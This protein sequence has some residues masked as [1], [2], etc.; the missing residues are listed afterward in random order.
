M[1][2]WGI[3]IFFMCSIIIISFRKLYT[4]VLWYLLTR[5]ELLCMGRVKPLPFCHIRNIFAVNIFWGQGKIYSPIAFYK[6]FLRDIKVKILINSTPFLMVLDVSFLWLTPSVFS[7]RNL[8]RWYTQW[9]GF[10]N[11]WSV[12]LEF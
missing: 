2:R 6:L 7:N 9:A 4:S 8:L 10:S 3:C 12:V 5:K 1:S 11:I